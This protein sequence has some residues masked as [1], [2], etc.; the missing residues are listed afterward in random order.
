MNGNHAET[1]VPATQTAQK[2]NSQPSVATP[3]R[4]G[5]EKLERGTHTYALGDLAY[6]R[7]GDKGN[8]CNIGTFSQR[9]LRAQ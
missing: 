4:S 6:T 9:N 7:S 2:T 8:K 5:E 3:V 1:F